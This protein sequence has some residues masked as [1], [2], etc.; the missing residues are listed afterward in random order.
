M[1]VKGIDYISSPLGQNLVL[2]M[3]QRGKT[4]DAPGP[5]ARMTTITAKVSSGKNGELCHHAVDHIKYWHPKEK[6]RSNSNTTFQSNITNSEP[7]SPNNDDH[8]NN[9]ITE[10]N[11]DNRNVVD[12]EGGSGATTARTKV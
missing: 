3:S 6:S 8:H 5:Y 7:T 1:K 10:G 11:D 12:R 2:Q 9:N 4:S